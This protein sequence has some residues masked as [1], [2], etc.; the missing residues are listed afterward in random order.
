MALIKCSECGADVS[1]KA[2]MCPKC[3]CPLD[4]T[5]QIISD[6]K[7]KKKKKK[8][9][10]IVAIILAIMIVILI[11]TGY[12]LG[13][14]NNTPDNIAIRLIEQDFGKDI[15]I[16]SIYYN[17]ELNGCMVEFSADG[18]D[19]TATVHLDDKVVGYKSVLDEYTEQSNNATT[20][21]EKRHC[22]Q[23]LLDYME[24]FDINWDLQIIMN[25]EKNG[26]EKIK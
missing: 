19:N 9:I 23:Q 25:P 21:K 4:I 3:G 7:K 24:I 26:W 1:E 20:D 18:K 6:T 12:F 2:S 16:E 17:S 10:V 5:K 13:K 11:L 15:R 8:I 22:S 14:H